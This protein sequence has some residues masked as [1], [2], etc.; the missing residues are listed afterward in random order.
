M[1]RALRE[2]SGLSQLELAL[3]LSDAGIRVDQAHIHRIESGA[4]KRPTAPTL[5]AILTVGLNVPYRVRIDVLAAFGY[6]LRWELPTDEDI[7][8]ER[9]Y[10]AD[11]LNHTIW[12]AYMVDHAHRIWGWNRLFPRL[13]GNSADDPGNAGYV[14]LTVLDILFNP[15]VGTNRQ[16][17]NAKSFG[18]VAVAWFKV[19]TK[20]YRQES[21]FHDLITRAKTWP[22]FFEIWDQIPEGPQA[23]LV[24][25]PVI[26]VE[27]HVPGLAAHLRFRAI[28]V[29]MPFDPRFAILHMVPLNVETQAICAAWAAEDVAE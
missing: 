19:M 5:D 25:P 12:P 6:Q 17:A 13:V 9:R 26:P 10:N 15:A 21:W 20:P 8:F 14:G 4:I 22:G 11:A 27:I 2:T 23:L 24:E 7:E 1:L 28:Q 18:P 16:I 3:R 29:A